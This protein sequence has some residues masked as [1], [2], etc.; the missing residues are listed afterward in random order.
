MYRLHLKKAFSEI[1]QELL[2]NDVDG[3]PAFILRQGV[4]FSTAYAVSFAYSK[5]A[6]VCYHRREI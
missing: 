4:P 1:R 2:H 6:L 5:E 3:R